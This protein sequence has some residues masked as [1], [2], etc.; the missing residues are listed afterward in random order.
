[1]IFGQGDFGELIIDRARELGFEAV[2]DKN[3]RRGAVLRV[4]NAQRVLGIEDHGIAAVEA[5]RDLAF[6]AFALAVHL[7]GAEGSPIDVDLELFNRRDEQMS[8][9]GFAPEHGREQPDHRRP[10]DRRS[11]VEPGAVASDAH[12]GMAAALRIP[13]V[14]RRQ[15]ALV[16]QLLQLDEAQ[17]LELDRRAGFGHRPA[18]VIATLAK[19]RGSNPVLHHL[20]CFVPRIGYGVLAMTAARPQTAIVTG[21]GKRVGAAIV[22]ALVADGWAVVAHVHHDSDDVPEGAVKVVADLAETS[23]AEAIFAAASDL[24]PVRLLVNN[25]ARFAWDGFGEFKADE[26]DAHMAVNARAPALLIDRFTREH[27][28]ASDAL[29]INLLD[30]KIAAPN[31][32]FLSYTLSKQALAGLTDLAARALAQRRIR[33]NGIAPGLMLRSSGQSEENFRAMHSNN[34]LSR[35][36][37]PDDIVAA[38][39]YLVEAPCVTGQLLVIDSGQRFMGVGR[40]VQFLGDA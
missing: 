1:M 9:V 40:D 30:S 28:G 5:K 15:A 13:L 23:C 7:D 36:V 12:A 10:P 33:V 37:E 26:L 27:D 14:N 3:A 4:E 2:A 24:P 11:L 35:G 19:A 32:D 8:S 22:R 20:D 17:S 39:R 21:G 29:V 31:P 16:D 6:A 25:A 34:P 38:I 18:S